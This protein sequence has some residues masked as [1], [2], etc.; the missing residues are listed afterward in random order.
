LHNMQ[1]DRKKRIPPLNNESS[2]LML[3]EGPQNEEHVVSLR[4]PLQIIRRRIRF[5]TLITCL[6]V[7]AAVGFS[8]LQTPVYEAKI[9]ILVGIE[10]DGTDVQPNL[11]S[12]ITGLQLLTLTMADAVDTRPVAEVITDELNLQ[13]SPEA[14]LE[15]LSAE[16]V[17][18][19][20][21]IE[22]S[23]KDTNPRQAQRIV[24]RI[25][26]EF[27]EQ[28]SQVSPSANAVTATVWEWA[29][30][31]QAPVSPKP[32]LNGLLALVVGGMVGLGLAFLLEHLDD[33]WRSPQEA[34]QTFGVPALG[35]IP[36][37][38]AFKIKRRL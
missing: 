13:K 18:N 1:L 23:Y 37:F 32:L 3:V 9:M 25:G 12:D 26:Q 33:R 5:I 35:V 38:K 24:N 15:D 11:G 19:T 14:L 22:V 17:S 36:S 34:E 21:F 10:R 7:G 2:S 16:Q 20:Q 8:L 29:T 31:P 30:T 6:F 27:S 4:E 28:V